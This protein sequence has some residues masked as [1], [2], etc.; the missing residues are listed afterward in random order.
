MSTAKKIG[1]SLKS[2]TRH[3]GQIYT[4]TKSNAGADRYVLTIRN[5]D[6]SCQQG[7]QKPE[8]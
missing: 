5:A 4:L 3:G 1:L 6:S 2:D 7:Q 8:S